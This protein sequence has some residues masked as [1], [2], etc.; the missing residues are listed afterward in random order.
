VLVGYLQLFVDMWCFFFFLAINCG[1]A[2]IV[3]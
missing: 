1:Y 3:F 2:M